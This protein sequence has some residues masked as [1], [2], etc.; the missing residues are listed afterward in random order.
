LQLGLLSIAL[1]ILLTV[2]PWI[3]RLWAQRAAQVSTVSLTVDAVLDWR[4]TYGDLIGKPRDAVL[5]RFGAPTK[6]DGQSLSWNRSPRTGD[7]NVL[8]AL[9]TNSKDGIV[10]LLKV[11]ARPSECLDPIEILKKASL[12]EFNTGTYTDTLLNYFA[13]TTKDERNVLQFTA[14]ESAV[15]FRAVMFV[16]K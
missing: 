13:A 6:E 4:D 15:R 14:S 1:A 5:E 3:P 10:Q 8:A 12:F 7:R 16:L 11:F 9:N 2:V